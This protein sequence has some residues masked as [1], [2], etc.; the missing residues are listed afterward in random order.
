MQLQCFI[1]EFDISVGEDAGLLLILDNATFDHKA[2]RKLSLSWC[3][4]PPATSDQCEIFGNNV[5]ME[6][7]SA[8]ENKGSNS[9]VQIY[10]LGN[11]TCNGN[12]GRFVLTNPPGMAAFQSCETLFRSMK[13]RLSR[14]PKNA[15]S[16]S[17]SKNVHSV[18]LEQTI[19]TTQKKVN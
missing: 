5:L 18:A 17:T 15:S 3:Y 14:V 12:D 16:S 11:E 6:S 9:R 1:D 4:Y 13:E 19:S 10:V 8:A 2:L 7:L